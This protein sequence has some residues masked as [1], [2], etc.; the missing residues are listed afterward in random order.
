MFRFLRRFFTKQPTPYT[1]HRAD[2]GQPVVPV[3]PV[4][5]PTGGVPPVMPLDRPAADD[6]LQPP[7]Q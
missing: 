6:E 1:E 4:G 3:V 5:P 2:Q 7:G